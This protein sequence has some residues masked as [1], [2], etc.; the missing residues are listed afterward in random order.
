[1]AHLYT[2][3]PGGLQ[4]G[5]L[6]PLLGLR[7]G[8]TG[9]ERRCVQVAADAALLGTRAETAT[10]QILGERSLRL[11]PGPGGDAVVVRT[12]TDV[13]YTRG[14]PGRLAP[15]QWNVLAEGRTA[16]GAA[17]RL[18]SHPDV[19]LA[20]RGPG[21]AWV[22][23]SGGRHKG[24]GS[25]LLLALD[26]GADAPSVWLLDL[27]AAARPELSIAASTLTPD[28][29]AEAARLCD[30][31]GHERSAAALRAACAAGGAW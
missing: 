15:G 17:G 27:D 31:A 25:R 16:W 24:C 13:V 7:L 20:I 29:L 2:A 6:I 5:I 21:A 12:R 22:C 3:T 18:G 30:A 1:M 4:P 11:D 8:E 23:F 26:R 19:L 10:L 28:E 9:R 14:C